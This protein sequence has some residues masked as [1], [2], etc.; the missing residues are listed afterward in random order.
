MPYL[1][2][3]LEIGPGAGRDYPVVVRSAAGEARST[4]HFPYD[5]LALESKLKDLRIAL[6][7]SANVHRKALSEEEQAVQ[8][9]GQRLFEALLAGDVRAL[10]DVSRVKAVQDGLL[11]VRLRLR[12]QAP[13]LA[14][15]PWEYL[16]DT[17]QSEYLCLSR[18]T[19]LVRYPEIAQPIQPLKVKPPL[20]ILGM[21]VSPSDMDPL[22][23]TREQARMRAALANLEQEGR[24]ELTWLAGQTWETLQEAMWGGPWHVFHFIGHGGFDPR[25]EEGVLA[26]AD[27]RGRTTLLPA[28]HLARLLANHNSLRLVILNACEGGKSNDRDL[29]SSTAAT[30]ARRGIPAVLAM[31]E[32]I[33]DHA[34][35]Q[36]TRTFYR[37]LA[38]GMPVDAAV[39]EARTAISLSAS[40]TLEWG[41]PVLY[42]RAPDSQL[43]D[44]T[45][46]PIPSAKQGI[47]AA[48]PSFEQRPST[49]HIPQEAPHPAQ[50]GPQANRPASETPGTQAER[51]SPSAPQ[52]AINTTSEPAISS[53]TSSFLD[54]IGSSS[55]QNTTP[56][57][58]TP[59]LTYTG[60]K[61]WVHALAWSPDG[62][63]IASAGQ[64]KTVQTWDA[65]SGQYAVTY[66]SHTDEVYALA[67]TPNSQLLASGSKD[68]SMLVWHAASA[69]LLMTYRGHAGAVMA[70]AWSPD[71]KLLV[72][73]GEDGLVQIW[74]AAS[75]KPLQ[76]YR[77][78]SDKINAVAWSP[79]GK[80]IAS[81]SD[82]RTVQ[83]WD[84]ASGERLLTY[85]RHKARIGAV[86]WSPDG[87]QVA[88]AA[89][90]EMGQ[91]VGAE[92][93]IAS[94][95]VW[96][97][98]TGETIIN[99]QGSGYRT[100]TLA[101]SPD[102]TRIASAD[103]NS[104]LQVW[105]AVTGQTISTYKAFLARALAWSPDSTRI[106]VEI[107]TDKV[108]VWQA[109]SASA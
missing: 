95:Q 101:W 97:A 9:F 73:G 3:D 26:L 42:L 65:A 33:T 41:T 74:D 11:G 98:S 67:W 30:L 86:A 40:Q 100:Y 17:R 5:E 61:W 94:A 77:R 24:V 72:S 14:A 28:T 4:M 60:H 37:A 63:R 54:K 108:Q 49:A 105:D 43:F 29:F 102:G 18:S 8:E 7:R 62:K 106:A 35:I 96:N 90:K 6:L 19:P 1:D 87:T 20:R 51:P 39:A 10:F 50:A 104:A 109:P 82:D 38:H 80:R 47:A 56:E 46:Q 89:R 69:N 103:G 15:L 58:M 99:Y 53:S 27:E 31:Q 55:R 92:G 23:V 59:L 78:H 16:Y 84:V 107:D 12:I 22:D 68:G 93:R 57:E 64:D 66:R 34:A 21:I 91:S 75:G 79:D 13:E 25:R 81:G 70:V 76:V 48:Q 83:I 44:L 45:E 52:P 71:G 2:F 88:S 85:D 36:L 32:E